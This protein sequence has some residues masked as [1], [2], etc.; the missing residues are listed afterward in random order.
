M[1]VDPDLLRAIPDY[2]PDA[3][4]VFFGHYWLPAT[5]PKAPLAPNIACLDFSAGLEGPMVAYRWDERRK[6]VHSRFIS[7]STI[8]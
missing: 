3:P 7:A 4:P 1:K 2:R 6:L 5:A 8:I